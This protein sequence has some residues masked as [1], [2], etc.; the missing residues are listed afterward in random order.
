MKVYRHHASEITASPL[1]HT[2]GDTKTLILCSGN[3]SNGASQSA[4]PLAKAQRA[5]AQ[6]V[7]AVLPGTEA[8][9]L[10]WLSK[11]GGQQSKDS[12][13]SELA[14][15][16]LGG[17]S[18]LAVEAAWV[19]SKNV[20][21]TQAGQVTVPTHLAPLKA[22]DFIC[23]TLE[24][25]ALTLKTSFQ[26]KL[27]AADAV[28]SAKES[29]ADSAAG[30]TAPEKP[31]REFPGRFGDLSLPLPM[32]TPSTK[33]VSVRTSSADRKRRFSC[34]GRT[35]VK[36]LRQF[37]SI[38]RAGAGLNHSKACFGVTMASADRER[39]VIAT[40]VELRV[41][42]SSCLTKCIDATPLV[43]IPF[44]AR[45]LSDR[46]KKGRSKENGNSSDWPHETVYCE[47]LCRPM[48]KGG[49]LAFASAT[50]TKEANLGKET[51][52]SSFYTPNHQSGEG[53]IY[54]GS[55]SGE[56]Q[57]FDLNTGKRKWSFKA[58][59]RIESGAAC[60]DDGSTVFFGCHDRKLYAI[61]CNTGTVAWS[62]ETGDAIKCTPVCV[63]EITYFDSDEGLKGQKKQATI[64]GAVLVGSHDGI[65]RSVCQTDGGLLWSVD[66]GGALFASPAYGSSSH[67]VY[68]ATTRGRVIAVDCRVVGTLS[69]ETK[70]AASFVDG[71]LGSRDIAA[72]QPLLL[73]EHQLPAPCF[74]TPS[75][76]STTGNLVLGC[77]DGALYCFSSV[78]DQLWVSREGRK[79]V[80]SSP[81]ILP[82]LSKKVD[83]E[84]NGIAGPHVIWGCHD[85]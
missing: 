29:S 15:A 63:P 13:I 68:G 48:S 19:V 35:E 82:P 56:F 38:S 9:L 14:F 8:A 17:T 67:T 12:S 25:V 51:L 37:L 77:V 53:T 55:H 40:K 34:E 57:A 74:S 49:Q 46:Q 7:V 62:F 59:G 52:V 6:A 30:R 24:E 83:A 50:G 1:I 60:S 81:C 4:Q 5:V 80:F 10:D 64:Q 70:D 31:S 71:R 41:G 22:D 32:V 36:E 39:V 78:G 26:T 33:L 2:T 27:G 76:C 58:S 73:W 79:A 69:T 84:E 43:V 72:K 44:K 21:Q 16:D 45:V 11:I 61:D 85:G 66:C 3:V 23:N 47:C 28:N 42:W 65:L 54:I 18:L 20:V 75:I